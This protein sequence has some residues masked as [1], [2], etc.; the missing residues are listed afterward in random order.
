MWGA[1]RALRVERIGHA[2]RAIDDPELVQHL[3]EQRIP[4]ELC[5]LSNVRTGVVGS[6]MNHP[7]RRYFDLGIPVSVNTDDPLFFGT[8][9]VDELA[10]AQQVHQFTRDEVKRLIVS[11]VESSWLAADHKARLL[12]D[13][14][15]ASVWDE[16]E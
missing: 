16:A 10:A 11:A 8:S 1:I 13:F 15:S 3:A 7:L 5:P 12:K 9:L 14:R 6:M 2:T 4:L